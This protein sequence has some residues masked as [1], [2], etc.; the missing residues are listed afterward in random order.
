M[1]PPSFD[2]RRFLSGCTAALMALIAGSILTPALAF[3]T[4]PLW[5]RRPSSGVSDGFS[6]AGAVASIPIGTWTLLPI[7]IVRQDGWDKTRQSRSVWALAGGTAPG[8]VKVLSPICPHLGCPIAWVAA[9][10][11]FF[12]PCHGSVFNT[13]GSFVSGPSS[14]GMDSLEFQIRDG[15][16]WVRWQDFRTGVKDKIAVEV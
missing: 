1:S 2:R 13:D 8:D 4:S 9:K 6:D 12:C 5:R 7:E 14:R 11:D 16:L 10:W 3:V 15:H